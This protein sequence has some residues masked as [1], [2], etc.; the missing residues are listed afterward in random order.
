[1][2]DT[3][4]IELKRKDTVLSISVNEQTPDMVSVFWVYLRPARGSSDP[5]H[6][7][8]RPVS[9][10]SDIPE[11]FYTEIRNLQGLEK[12]FKEVF[13][14]EKLSYERTLHC[15]MRSIVINLLELQ[16]LAPKGVF[17]MGDS[18][19]AEP[20]IGGNG[21]NAAIRDGVELAE[22]ISKSCTAG[23]SKWY[24]TRYHTWKEGVRK[25]EGMIAEIHKENVSTL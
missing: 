3:N 8:N 11:E 21:A 17:F 10:A 18:I 2:K 15:L 1:M 4:V 20:I 25:R 22:F 12:P 13:D 5:L 23:I 16:H 24:E 9:G 6:K 14:A 7:P 19:H